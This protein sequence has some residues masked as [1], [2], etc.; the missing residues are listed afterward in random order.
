[1]RIAGGVLLAVASAIGAGAW[2]PPARAQDAPMPIPDCGTFRV[3]GSYVLVRNLSS[4]DDC[5]TFVNGPVTIDLNGFDIFGFGHVGVAIQGPAT[6]DE[7]TVRN[8]A[9]SAFEVGIL[10]G[11]GARVE[12]VQTLD[13]ETGI[14]VGEGS[15]VT[16]NNGL[17]DGRAVVTGRFSTV[18]DNTASLSNEVGIVVGEGSIVSGNTVSSGSRGP[19]DEPADGIVVGEGSTVSDNTAS[20]NGR[21]GIVVGQFST[22]S[23]NTAS[24]NGQ[25]G[26]RVGRQPEP[27]EVFLKAS[28]T[29][30]G[31]TAS[32]NGRD[33]IVVGF[34]ST[35][36]GN[37][38]SENRRDGIQAHCP[39]NIIGNTAL[40]NGRRQIARV[41]RVRAALESCPRRQN[42]P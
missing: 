10:L 42:L 31:N 14:E 37:T 4:N 26:I 2:G 27:A 21:H 30:S 41:F 3:P 25:D 22:V 34:F 19:E 8:G 17:G 35:V 29:V 13:N 5:I 9:I 7:I 16:G 15:T 18:T 40:G 36:S 33:G 32:G 24:R 1:M 39:A 23:G 6:A 11:R 12:G 38:A 20:F 28:S